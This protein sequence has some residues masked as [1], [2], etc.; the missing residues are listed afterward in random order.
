MQGGGK[1]ILEKAM[2]VKGMVTLIRS[3]IAW[4]AGYTSGIVLCSAA[5]ASLS[6]RAK[7]IFFVNVQLCRHTGKSI[8]TPLSLIV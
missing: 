8:Y 6:G 1:N 7:V 3:M 5:F 4:P 2:L